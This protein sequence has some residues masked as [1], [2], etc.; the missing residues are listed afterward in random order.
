M[1]RP[2]PMMRL[3]TIILEQD[4]KDW[5]RELGR[6]GVV[7]LTRNPVGVDNTLWRMSDRTQE[8]SRCDRLRARI[9]ELL[10][11]LGGAET[12]EPPTTLETTLDDAERVLQEVEERTMH[13]VR[14]RQDL[15]RQKQ[16]LDATD[17]KVGEY[18]G[19]G[20]RLDW[21]DSGMFL[22]YVAGSLPRGALAGFHPQRGAVM[23]PLAVRQ[24]RQ[25]ILA[26]T[27]RENGIALEEELRQLG[28]E[29]DELPAVDGATVDSLLEETRRTRQNV[30]ES[31]M[32]VAKEMQTL[33]LEATP[34]LYA[35]RQ[36]AQVERKLYQAEEC[37][38]R[39]EASVLISGWIPENEA[40]KARE[41]LQTC[42]GGR[43]IIELTS[44]AD[45]PEEEIPVLLSHAWWLRPFELLVK[46][47]GLPKYREVA[48]T[49]FLAASYMVMF[50]MMFGDV[51]HGGL[52]ALA[53]L[54]W[55]YVRRR[56]KNQN[57]GLLLLF[58]GLS[59]AGFGVVYGSYFGHPSL[60]HWALWRDPLEGDPME[61]MLL[62]VTMGVVLMSVGLLLNM[63]NRLSHGDLLNGLLDQ[64][65]LM[66]LVFYWAALVSAIQWLAQG[67]RP[68]I[69]GACGFLVVF[70]LFCWWL[71]E[72][73]DCRRM[74]RREH[75]SSH[76]SMGI[77]A[78]ESFVA[79]FEGVL[80]YLSNTISFVR[81]AAYA[82]S[83]AALMAA[84][85]MMAMEVSRFSTSGPK[86][87]V[88]VVVFGNLAAMVLE[89]V[90]AAVQ[91]LRLEFYEFFGKFY[92][93]D[94]QPFRPFSL[95]PRT[96]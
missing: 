41:R 12:L 23:V 62:A 36:W 93:G 94:G 95:D 15:E 89:G 64:H 66:G 34:K 30:M 96:V 86:F 9:G 73:L 85:Y 19:T 79:A 21:R 84:I 16:E 46:A 31:L 75:G 54:A 18:E 87:A 22:Y 58:N 80:T 50:G 11:L 27:T 28:F 90:V 76:Q 47:Y 13:F 26:I 5:M 25:R 6:L 67:E 3:S 29:R 17:E 88:V 10:N 83:H 39:T 52:L 77:A 69:G 55:Y 63:V 1:F 40:S 91:A 57:I 72:P 78:I 65:G 81:L 51:G 74:R 53:G 45:V 56:S 49:L 38:L 32:G 44:P 59:S 48:P 42:T 14:R 43:C 33:A 60:Q 37:S 24:Q 82:M 8:L 71:K 92:S 61:L 68:A 70:S 4:E 7:Q 35:M 20:W 2:Q